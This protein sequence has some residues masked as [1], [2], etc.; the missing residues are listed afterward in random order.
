MRRKW[1]VGTAKEAARP[2]SRVLPTHTHTLPVV[3]SKPV[4]REKAESWEFV[5]HITA[6]MFKPLLTPAGCQLSLNTLT[7]DRMAADFPRPIPLRI[8]PTYSPP[9]AG[10]ITVTEHKNPTWKSQG[11]VR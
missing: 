9:P 5:Q 7:V 8:P 11:M 1:G 3:Y 2:S 4:M 10:L 6:V